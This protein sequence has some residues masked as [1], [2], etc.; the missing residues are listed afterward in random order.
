MFYFFSFVLSLQSLWQSLLFIV[1]D[2]LIIILI[3]FCCLYIV[4]NV[5]VEKNS[6]FSM[7][8]NISIKLFNKTML[9]KCLLFIVTCLLLHVAILT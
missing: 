6:K 3:N 9:N 1:C 4:I 8:Y 5:L 2:I 7:F